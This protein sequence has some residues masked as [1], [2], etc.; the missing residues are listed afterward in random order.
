MENGHFKERMVGGREDWAPGACQRYDRIIVCFERTADYHGN[1]NLTAPQA[2]KVHV[3]KLSLVL[4]FLRPRLSTKLVWFLDLVH[5]NIQ[6]V[7]DTRD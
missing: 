6:F 2:P 5:L 3:S 1:G 4:K 7:I